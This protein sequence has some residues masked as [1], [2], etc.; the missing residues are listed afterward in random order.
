MFHGAEG[1]GAGGFIDQEA[2]LWNK[3][4]EL[5][6]KLSRQE[7]KMKRAIKAIG[8]QMSE[9]FDFDG[10]LADIEVTETKEV[11][12]VQDELDNIVSD[13]ETNIIVP[14]IIPEETIIDEIKEVQEELVDLSDATDSVIIELEA[15]VKDLKS[16]LKSMKELKTQA[17]EAGAVSALPE[18]EY[19]AEAR[20]FLKEYNAIEF[21]KKSLNDK[22]KELKDEYKEMG[23][24]VSSA[25]KAQKEKI[26]EIKE[27][28]EE[29]E[30]IEGYKNLI[31]DDDDLMG[32][33]TLLAG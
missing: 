16:Q 15:Q 20:S 12:E 9:D 14:G 11:P 32:D 22:T 1:I 10:L 19:S 5:E 33:V 21:E 29:A 13:I 25:L 4:R 7:K 18:L 27:T 28:S 31:G 26:K 23:V 17:V 8:E 24:D 30:L 2:Q 6:E 3:L